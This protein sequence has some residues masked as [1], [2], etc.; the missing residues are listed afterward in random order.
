M[1]AHAVNKLDGVWIPCWE[2]DIQ[3]T[4]CLFEQRE[5][6][7]RGFPVFTQRSVQLNNVTIWRLPTYIIPHDP[8]SREIRFSLANDRACASQSGDCFIGL[9]C[10][11]GDEHDVDSCCKASR[12]SRKRLHMDC[13]QTTSMKTFNVLVSSLKR[14]CWSK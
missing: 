7:T 4:Q 12:F 5:E 11:E 3:R 2:Q 1:R 10:S 8:D 13:N 14:R 6:V 9:V